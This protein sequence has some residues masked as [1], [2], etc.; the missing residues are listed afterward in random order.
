MKREAEK[1]IIKTIGDLS[2][3]YTPYVIFTDWVKMTAIAIQNSCCALHDKTWQ[4]REK[5]YIDTAKKY[6][7][8]YVNIGFSQ[9]EIKSNLLMAKGGDGR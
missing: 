4:T 7:N 3:S 1:E 2:G 9:E 6:S 8:Q 5:A